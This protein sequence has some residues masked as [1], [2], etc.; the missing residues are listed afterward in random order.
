MLQEII[1]VGA[2]IHK[3]THQREDIATAIAIVWLEQLQTAGID[4]VE[5]ERKEKQIHIQKQVSKEW[6]PDR[7]DKGPFLRLI[8]FKYGRKPADWQFWFTEVMESYFMQFWDMIDHPERALPCAWI[9]NE[10]YGLCSNYDA[11]YDPPPAWEDCDIVEES[12]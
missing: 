6:L 1:L 7:R 8:S 12:D 11:E 5:Y 2:D 4:L 10:N 9:D 3:F